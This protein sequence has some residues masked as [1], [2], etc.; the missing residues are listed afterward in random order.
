MPIASYPVHRNHWNEPSFLPHT[1]RYLYT[2]LVLS[3]LLSQ[4]VYMKD[5]PMLQS[6][7]GSS[8][9]SD[10]QKKILTVRTEARKSLTTLAFSVS[11]YWVSCAVQHRTI[12]SLVSTLLPIFLS[13]RCMNKPSFALL[14]P[15]VVI[16]YFALLPLLRILCSTISCSQGCPHLHMPAL[17]FLGASGPTEHLLPSAHWFLS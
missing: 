14:K 6:L 8:G 10:P 9:A 13:G 17:P 3:L 16:L 5:A 1:I 4:S 7:S 11:R 12:F 15:K 2:L